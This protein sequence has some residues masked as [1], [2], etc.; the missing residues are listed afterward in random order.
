MHV[1]DKQTGIQIS[2]PVKTTIYLVAH[3]L[4]SPSTSPLSCLVYSDDANPQLGCATGPGK[5]ALT[6]NSNDADWNINEYKAASGRH[7]SE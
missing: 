6:R 7:S 3:I 2:L 1:R 4:V 5:G